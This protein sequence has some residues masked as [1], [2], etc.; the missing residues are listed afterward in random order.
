MAIFILVTRSFLVSYAGRSM[1]LK[2]VWLRGS[3]LESE[4]R[5]IQNFIGPFDPSRSANPPTGSRDVPVTNCRR[6][7]RSSSDNDSTSSQNHTICLSLVSYL[8]YTVFLFQSSTS[9]S[10]SPMNKMSNSRSSN[11]WRC[12]RGRISSKPLRKASICSVHPRVRYAV[13]ASRTNSSRLSTVTSFLSPSGQRTMSFGSPN[14]SYD[15]TK[16]CSI[17]SISSASALRKK[18]SELKT[19]TSMSFRSFS[20]SGFFSIC[21]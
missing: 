18:L 10:A 21:L 19:A 12:S 6:R 20:C 16:F 11:V 4:M 2:H 3:R 1:R 17:T 7:A 15:S 13:V 9:Y 14:S 8:R 5:S